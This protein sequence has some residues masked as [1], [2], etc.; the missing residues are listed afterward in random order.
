MLILS[1]IKNSTIAT[2]VITLVIILVII[3]SA[4]V[5]V[6]EIKRKIRS[7]FG[8]GSEQIIREV[9]KGMQEQESRPRS[10]QAMDS[11]V[12]PK[13]MK[14]FPDFNA[15]L[16]KTE[17]KDKMKEYLKGK[18][19][20]N[21]GVAIVKYNS[22]G[23]QKVIMFQTALEYTE[24]G[25][26]IQKRYDVDYTY[27]VEGDE[28]DSHVAA[29]CPNCGAPLAAMSSRVCRYCDTPIADVQGMV[30]KFTDIRES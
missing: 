6:R 7:L 21:H 12:L 11:V 10:L 22:S 8:A 4:K 26:K 29:N 13:I 1:L 27:M 14:D 20:K 23:L 24:G 3:I 17:V 15:T 9:V 5:I 25:N 16:A 30:W 18:N 2:L 19:V 28:N